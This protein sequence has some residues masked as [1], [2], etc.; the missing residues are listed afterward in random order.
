MERV[1]SEQNGIY[2]PLLKYE[3]EAEKPVKMKSGNLCHVAL[4]VAEVE[5]VGQGALAPVEPHWLEQ[6]LTTVLKKLHLIR[7][8]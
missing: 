6:R 5:V 3:P 2:I 4:E 7:M 8:L 1:G